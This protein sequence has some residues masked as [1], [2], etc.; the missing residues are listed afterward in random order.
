MDALVMNVEYMASSP[1]SCPWATKK[2]AQRFLVYDKTLEMTRIRSC[3]TSGPFFFTTSLQ[4]HR[5][6][7]RDNILVSEWSWF[8]QRTWSKCTNSQRCYFDDHHPNDNQMYEHPKVQMITSKCMN[9]SW[10][11]EL[12]E[13]RPFRS[14]PRKKRAPSYPMKQERQSSH[15]LEQI[16]L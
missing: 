3:L 10:S 7:G 9:S 4:P 15:L 2:R 11:S 5:N 1:L 6:D 14:K 16:E 13:S 8:T 12:W